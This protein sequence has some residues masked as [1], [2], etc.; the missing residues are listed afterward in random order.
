MI[1]ATLP[2]QEHGQ[3]HGFM[4]GL[5]RINPVKQCK[6]ERENQIQLQVQSLKM[7]FASAYK[8]AL[9]VGKRLILNSVRDKILSVRQVWFLAQRKQH[10]QFVFHLMQSRKN[11]PSLTS[12]S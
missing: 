9:V 3:A 1:V 4:G 6:G 8:E 7:V 2:F 11:A 5:K 12:S 10:K